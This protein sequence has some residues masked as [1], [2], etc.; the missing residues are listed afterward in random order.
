MQVKP[1]LVLLLLI[2]SISTWAQ[3]VVTGR[4]TDQQNNPLP[5]ATVTIQG[6]N[7]STQSDVNGNFSISV[8]NMNTKLVISSVG[9]ASRTINASDA[10][11]GVR[12][13]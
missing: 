11:Q 1:L 7:N 8:P 4:V 10:A 6:T 5:S 13:E 2:F 3:T 9:F 12:L